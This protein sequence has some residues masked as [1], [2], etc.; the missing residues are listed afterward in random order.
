M[1][2]HHKKYRKVK[3][4]NRKLKQEIRVLNKLISKIDVHVNV[5]NKV[6]G[7]G[8]GKNVSGLG[9]DGS[10]GGNTGGGG[11]GNN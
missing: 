11:G 7:G 10:S 2:D 5:F 6:E 1:C 4:E 3:R 8:G 9:Y